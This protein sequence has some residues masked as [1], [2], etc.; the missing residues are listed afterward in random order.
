M[1]FTSTR[2]RVIGLSKAET[3]RKRLSQFNSRLA[4]EQME[5]RLLLTNWSGDIATNT[6]WV[7]TQ[8]QN[9]VGNVHVDLGVTLTIQAGTVV[10][11]NYGG[12][13]LTVDGTLSAQGTTSQTIIFTSAND[14]SP[15]G[16]ANNAG[17]GDWGAIQF[18]SDSSANVLSNIKVNYGG[19]WG[20]N[21]AIIDNGTAL[22]F[23][24]GVI[25]NSGTAGI[26]SPGPTP[27]LP[28]T[29]SRTTRVPPSAW[30]WLP[31]RT[32]PAPA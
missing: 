13:N 14:N 2:R 3:R 10:K 7:N 26:T 23:D 12:I 17:N 8:V 21:A 28:A 29:R 6:T 9:I 16:G 27:R 4:L 18:N 19:G 1:F 15:E 25:G 20:N 11:F 31:T 5:D 22:K 24:N 32:S 30:T